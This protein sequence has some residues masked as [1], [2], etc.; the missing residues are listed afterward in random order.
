MLYIGL[1]PSSHQSAKPLA[2]Q[3]ICDRC[4]SSHPCA[5]VPSVSQSARPATVR[6]FAVKSSQFKSCQVKSNQVQHDHSRQ[7]AQ[8][9]VTCTVVHPVQCRS[10]V[11]SSPG[12]SQVNVPGVIARTS[13]FP[14]SQSSP[15]MAHA[16]ALQLKVKS[17][18]VRKERQVRKGAVR[19]GD[20]TR[21]SILRWRP[22]VG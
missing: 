6:A 1:S 5:G 3:A 9:H 21:P 19:V 15:A 10:Q 4:S 17:N 14:D 2:H 22:V 7:H 11:K 18:L 13:R 16:R 12:S 20:H 8:E